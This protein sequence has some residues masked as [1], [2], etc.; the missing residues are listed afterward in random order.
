MQLH[1]E[2]PPQPAS[3]IPLACYV[4]AHP[5][6]FLRLQLLHTLCAL[7]IV[8]FLPFSVSVVLCLLVYRAFLRVNSRETIHANFSVGCHSHIVDLRFR[9]TNCRLLL[10]IDHT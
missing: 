1:T 8:L 2:I 9:I 6:L 3:C 7:L 4:A 5:W 10:V